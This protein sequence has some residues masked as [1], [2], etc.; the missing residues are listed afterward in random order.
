MR[1]SWGWRSIR[2]C[3]SAAAI[4]VVL[5]ACG[6]EMSRAQS[7]VATAP[8]PPQSADAT[9]VCNMVTTERI[10]AVGDVHGGFDQFV[11]I[12]REARIID[13]RR[14]WA[15]GHAIFVQ[16]GDTTDR[17]PDS[18]KVIDL[19]RKLTDEAANAGGRVHALLGNHEAMRVLGIYRDV[20]PGEYAAF[21]APESDDLRTRYL[22]LLLAD[23][24]KR[25]KA[26]GTEF[27][28]NAFRTQFVQ[29][30]PL[31]SVEM[32]LAFAAKG[33]YGKWL[34]QRDAMVKINGILFM[35][36]G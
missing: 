6:I 10:V 34:R 19:L 9:D 20:G 3:F 23:A 29:S 1:I 18:R 26:A 2:R 33:D 5:W 11:R 32:Q 16:T 12:L 30:T 7:A 13:S 24:A 22:D 36:G 25:A 21:R 28:E 17:G 35:H 27:D 4:A 8:A 15:G 14:R 31:G